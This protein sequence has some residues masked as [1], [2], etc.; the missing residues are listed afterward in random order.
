MTSMIVKQEYKIYRQLTQDQNRH[1]AV[2]FKVGFFG[3]SFPNMLRNKEF[4]YRANK[5]T[6]R[7]DMKDKMIR[8]FPNAFLIENYNQ[9]DNQMMISGDKK[10]IQIQKVE[11]LTYM[12][13]RDFD[14]EHK[15]KDLEELEIGKKAKD[16]PIK[17]R[18]YYLENFKN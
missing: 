18:A 9:P 8:F 5:L 11:P 7:K 16:L 14:L 2:Y 3:Q 12:E 13:L 17:E 6:N 10:F 4:I 1:F 15:T